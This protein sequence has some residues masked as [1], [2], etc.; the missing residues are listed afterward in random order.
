MEWSGVELGK[1][2]NIYL[3]VIGCGA[4]AGLL[5]GAGAHDDKV[6]S[7]CF[8]VAFSALGLDIMRADRDPVW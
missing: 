3:N 6:G 8:G 4:H 1:V 2:V 5:G 7:S